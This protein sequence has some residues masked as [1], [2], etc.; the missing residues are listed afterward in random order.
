MGIGPKD[1]T[2][3]KS[4]MTTVESGLY[5]LI[6]WRRPEWRN[7]HS[8]CL[9]VKSLYQCHCQYVSMSKS[10]GE[11]SVFELC[12]LNCV[13]VCVCVCVGMCLCVS[14]LTLQS[15]RH[16]N[17]AQLSGTSSWVAWRISFPIGWP[18]P[19]G[20]ACAIADGP[21]CSRGEESSGWPSRALTEGEQITSAEASVFDSQGFK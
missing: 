13:C 14:L 16:Q 6:Q 21:K 19:G 18:G 5:C 4:F 11:K 15:C 7:E 20:G 17:R 12:V 8:Q 10:D 2:V 3:S 1:P 9:S